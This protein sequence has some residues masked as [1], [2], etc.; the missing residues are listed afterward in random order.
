M[1]C[2][3]VGVDPRNAFSISVANLIAQ[4]KRSGTLLDVKWTIISA[5]VEIFHM[6]LDMKGLCL[7]WKVFQEN[8][9]SLLLYFLIDVF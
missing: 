8:E 4:L 6:F 1:R 5:G 7:L 9:E 3:S 2:E